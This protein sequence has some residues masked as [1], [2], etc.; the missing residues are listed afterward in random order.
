[1]VEIV[2][3]QRLISRCQKKL[4]RHLKKTCKEKIKCIVGYK[5]E[6]IKTNV[7]Y[8]SDYNFWFTTNKTE[9]LYRNAF[10]YGKPF[11][12]KNNSITVEINIPFKNIDRRV[13]G[14]FGYDLQ[15]EVMLLHRGRI[16]GGRKGIG[17]KLLFER[18]SDETILADDGGI[19]SEFCLIG[20]FKSE[21]LPMN[22]AHFVSQVF[23]I[24]N[25]RGFS[26]VNA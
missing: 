26:T 20:S 3:E 14:V 13:G 23:E 15:G 5:G 1:M 9:S 18:Y 10:G 24:K 7:H 25:L 8:S 2:T 17:K 4:I 21:F 12:G 22:I 11:K 6:S 19:I 16:G